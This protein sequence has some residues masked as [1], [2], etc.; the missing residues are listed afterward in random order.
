MTSTP[1]LNILIY[2]YSNIMFLINV[3]LIQ[4]IQ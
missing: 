2:K 1:V 3:Y 4:T